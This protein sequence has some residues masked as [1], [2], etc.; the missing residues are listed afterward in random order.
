MEHG[1][2]DVN[3]QVL[4][5]HVVQR[6][7]CCCVLTLSLSPLVI[8]FSC[9]LRVGRLK[10]LVWQI[11]PGCDGRVWQAVGVSAGPG[12]GQQWVEP[13]MNSQ[14]QQP[15]QQWAPIVAP[16]WRQAAPVRRS[17]PPLRSW[18]PAPSAPM[19]WA[20]TRQLQCWQ[21]PGVGVPQPQSSFSCWWCGQPFLLGKA[22]YFSGFCFRKKEGGT[23]WEGE[24]S[25]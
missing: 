16:K 21:P 8:G 23:E 19:G 3:N 13:V 12:L 25:F 15:Q 5:P 11:P 22:K 4:H 7:L 14:Q 9:S 24:F 18:Q 2:T 17:V 6:Q 20:V 1:L 10:N